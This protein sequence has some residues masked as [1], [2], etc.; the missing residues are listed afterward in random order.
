MKDM[1]SNLLAQTHV[2]HVE[3]FKILKIFLA[4]WIFLYLSPGDC[5]MHTSAWGGTANMGFW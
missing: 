2:W 3:V 5:V 4:R 1:L